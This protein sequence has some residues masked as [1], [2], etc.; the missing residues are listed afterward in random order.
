[1]MAFT[2]VSIAGISCTKFETCTAITTI[3]NTNTTNKMRMQIRVEK[4]RCTFFLSRK[5]HTGAISIESRAA[6]AMGIKIILP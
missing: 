1:M 5:R 2:L 4:V 3:K 6:K